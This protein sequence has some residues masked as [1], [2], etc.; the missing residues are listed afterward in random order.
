MKLDLLTQHQRLVR[1]IKRIYS[2]MP[3]RL[4]VQSSAKFQGEQGASLFRELA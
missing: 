4:S 1:V 2:A 3:S